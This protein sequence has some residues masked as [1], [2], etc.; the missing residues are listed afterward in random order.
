[1]FNLIL[2]ATLDLPELASSE[3]LVGKSGTLSYGASYYEDNL[4]DRV[5]VGKGLVLV[6]F[7]NKSMEA[8]TTM[9]WEYARRAN[10]MYRDREATRNY[11]SMVIQLTSAEFLPRVMETLERGQIQLSRRSAEADKLRTVLAV[12]M[13]IFLI[14]AAIILGIAAINITHTFLMVIYERKREIGIMRSLGA[15]R[16][17]VGVLFVGESLCIGLAGALMGNGV[18]FGLSHLADFAANE[19]IGDFPFRPETFFHF[20]W[21]FVALSL[22][23]AV[24]FSIVGAIFPAYRAASMD[25]ARTLTMS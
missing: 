25:P 18:A 21:W 8:G 5:P 3:S 17:N 14:M 16:L 7:S 6:G 12:A 9:P 11:N 1:M 13:A 24:F 2:D 20:D 10:A 22:G 4:S 19:Y 23:F 15:T